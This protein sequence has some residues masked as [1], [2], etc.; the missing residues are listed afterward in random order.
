MGNKTSN[1]AAQ[2]DLRS[3]SANGLGQEVGGQILAS[4]CFAYRG[5]FEL[6]R[7][8]YRKQIQLIFKKFDQEE[9]YLVDLM[10]AELQAWA[11]K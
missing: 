6:D 10:Q 2:G 7:E 9:A 8:T 1:P 4:K 3:G 5:N 11:K